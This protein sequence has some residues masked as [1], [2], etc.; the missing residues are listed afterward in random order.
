M[1]FFSELLIFV[2]AEYLL[3]VMNKYPDK[4][5]I[6]LDSD[7]VI[8]K[9]PTLFLEISKD[10]GLFYTSQHEVL[11]GTLFFNNTEKSKEILE[12]WKL[13]SKKMDSNINITNY[14]DCLDQKIL[15]K[16]LKNHDKD[17]IFIL[18]KEYISI[19]YRD[20]KNIVIIH[21]NASREL[22]RNIPYFLHPLRRFSFKPK[23]YIKYYFKKY[24]YILFVVMF[25]YKIIY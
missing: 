7:A 15:E 11:S 24:Y 19:F 5:I 9:Y 10:I 8:L 14:E 16:V 13:E 23:Y 4:K 25:L 6:W 20:K 1:C 17:N 18:P 22:K 21:Y 12:K 2:K 3:Q